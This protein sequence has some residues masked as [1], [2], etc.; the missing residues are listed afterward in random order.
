[1]K[2]QKSRLMP[3]KNNFPIFLYCIYKVSQTFYLIDNAGLGGSQE[4]A[5][6][7]L[8][9]L[10]GHAAALRGRGI[11]LVG[12]RQR[13]AN[14][15]VVTAHT[16]AGRN[17]TIVLQLVVDGV[18]H[19]RAR[20]SLGLLERLDLIVVALGLR[21]AVRAPKGRAK[22]PAV[23]RAPVQ[24]DRV[25]LVVACV[26][27]NCHNGVYARRQL[28]KSQELHRASGGQGLLRVEQAVS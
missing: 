25:L 20:R 8:G 21:V 26:R 16:N 24:N 1:M 9:V 27:G 11:V 15:H 22:E 2:Y 6:V 3:N 23:H 5:R 18:A 12:Q 14:D 10:L 13:L 7:L 19:A 4:G 17:D 28:A